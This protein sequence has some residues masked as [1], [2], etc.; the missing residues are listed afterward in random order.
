MFLIVFS[1]DL[2]M[3]RKIIKSFKLN[4]F[5]IFGDFFQFLVLF[6]HFCLFLIICFYLVQKPVLALCS[7]KFEFILFKM[8][9]SS[10]LAVNY[11][12]FYSRFHN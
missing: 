3:E 5:F 6:P 1:I 2:H 10:F 11:F 12:K 8:S 4:K 9:A 7:F